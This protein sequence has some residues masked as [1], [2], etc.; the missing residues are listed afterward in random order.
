[1]LSHVVVAS[2]ISIGKM[3][4]YCSNYMP[5][6]HCTAFAIQ[7]II[8]FSYLQSKELLHHCFA[9]LTEFAVIFLCNE[10]NLVPIFTRNV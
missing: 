5:F 8:D 9:H 1:M 4:V 3:P 6:I 7:E 2:Q 10:V